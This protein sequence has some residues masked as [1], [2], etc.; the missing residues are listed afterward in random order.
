MK[1]RS[2]AST[3]DPL[4]GKAFLVIDDEESMLEV[5]RYFLELEGFKVITASTGHE[6]VAKFRENPAEIGAVFLD[7]SMPDLAGG[8][9][10]LDIRKVRHDVPVLVVS[11][12]SKA[13]VIEHF[14]GQ[15]HTDFLQ[16]PFDIEELMEKVGS[17]FK[18]PAS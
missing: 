2:R 13:H 16:K 10:F 17:R 1:S 3:A 11:G 6:G 8:K 15:R 7:L 18:S 14:K 4:R 9:V 5:V 12:H